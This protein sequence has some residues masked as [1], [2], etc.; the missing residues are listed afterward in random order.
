MN[1]A[2]TAALRR[3]NPVSAPLRGAKMRRADESIVNTPS[4][5]IRNLINV[6][7]IYQNGKTAMKKAKL[8]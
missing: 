1:R 6:R 5:M 3:K 8:K 7:L 2:N 4:A